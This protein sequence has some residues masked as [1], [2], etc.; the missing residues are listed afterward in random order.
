VL[1]V[2]TQN[3]ILAKVQDVYNGRR[4]MTKPLK[5]HKLRPELLLC[6]RVPKPLHGLAP[7]VVMSS[8]W[9]TQTKNAAYKSHLYH[10]AACGVYKFEAKYRQWLEA[11]EVY[12]IDYLEGT[13]EYLETVPLC[14]MCH[15]YIHDGRMQAMMETGKLAV[16]K[17]RDITLHGDKVLAEVG[18]I[19]P[20]DYDGPFAPWKSWRLIVDGKEY[21]T[22]FENEE[23]W[24]I[25][26][27][28]N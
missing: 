2:K 3:A 25:T 6:K 26:I 16:A 5:V 22:L 21:P 10:C 11:H 12:E 13:A 4:K 23:A 8:L 18:Y 28:G 17:F 14:H 20:Q 9:W 1:A 15:N 27:K 7:R 19:K 24:K